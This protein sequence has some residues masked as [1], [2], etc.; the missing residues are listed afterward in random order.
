[1]PNVSFGKEKTSSDVEKQPL[2]G[3]E[4]KDVATEPLPPQ[5]ILKIFSINIIAQG[6]P[7]C[8]RRFAYVRVSWLHPWQMTVTDI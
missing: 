1:M 4:A 8:R 7:F 2:A 5:K 6:L 3:A